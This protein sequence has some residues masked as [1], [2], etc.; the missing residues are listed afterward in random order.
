MK[1]CGKKL[2]ERGEKMDG[3]SEILKENKKDGLDCKGCEWGDKEN[4]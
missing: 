2:M 4:G 1:R 3:E